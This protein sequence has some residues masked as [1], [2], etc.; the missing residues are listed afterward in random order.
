MNMAAVNNLRSGINLH[1]MSNHQT[2]YGDFFKNNCSSMKFSQAANPIYMN[3]PFIDQPSIQSQQLISSKPL[4]L[5]QSFQSQANSLNMQAQSQASSLLNPNKKT[6]LHPKSKFTPVEDQK[7]RELVAQFGDDNWDTISKMMVTR[8]QR[9]CRERWTNYLSPKVCNAPW[10]PEEDELL[11]KLHE[12][13]GA[14]WVKISSY[15]SNRTDT[16]IKNRW[17]VLMRQK[18][19]KEN[20]N[21]YNTRKD[22]SKVNEKETNLHVP[23]NIEDQSK[24]NDIIV[25]FETETQIDLMEE[26]LSSISCFSPDYMFDMYWI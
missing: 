8:N 16:N 21:K 25:N 13:I 14:K 5:Q 2:S 9:Q 1:T 19:A 20:A 24:E 18:K 6:K 11:K 3:F 7:L 4:M 15:F 22:E 26:S 17:M 23:A 12:E 10:T